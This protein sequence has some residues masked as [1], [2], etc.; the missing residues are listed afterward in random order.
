MEWIEAKE[1]LPIKRDSYL[2]FDKDNEI[3]VLLHF[4]NEAKTKKSLLITNPKRYRWLDIENFEPLEKQ[5]IELLSVT[6]CKNIIEV[7]DKFKILLN[8]NK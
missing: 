8:R 1:R 3:K 2:C 6:G 4:N 5:I 7:I